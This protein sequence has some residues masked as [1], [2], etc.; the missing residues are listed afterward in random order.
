MSDLDPPPQPSDVV[1]D[2]GS[3]TEAEMSDA[4]DATDDDATAAGE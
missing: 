4:D 2:H 3:N 1:A